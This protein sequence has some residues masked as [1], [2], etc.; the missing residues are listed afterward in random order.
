MTHLSSFRYGESLKEPPTERRGCSEVR[1][2]Y[3][4]PRTGK[5]C[6]E[7]PKPLRI[8]REPKQTAQERVTE[9]IEQEREAAEIAANMKARRE[10]ERRKKPVNGFG[11]SGRPVLVDGALFPSVTAAA[12][13]VGVD[14]AYLGK[15]LR[16]G[17][18]Q[19]HGRTVEFAE[20]PR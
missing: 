14:A 17:A 13:E 16:A 4:D 20:V 6:D 8:Q 12:N 3:F 2:S 19:V 9:R 5:P 11:R 7:K 1:V 10:K 15:Q 18:K